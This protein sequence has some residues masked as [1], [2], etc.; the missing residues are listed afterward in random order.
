VYGDS[1]CQPHWRLSICSPWLMRQ[2]CFI[3]RRRTSAKRCPG[4]C[5]VAPQSRPCPLA[6]ENSYAERLCGCGLR[7]MSE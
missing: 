7:T 5:K 3:A 1:A 4:E 2:N 6:A